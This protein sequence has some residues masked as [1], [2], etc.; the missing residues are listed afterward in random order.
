MGNVGDHKT[1]V[2]VKANSNSENQG[3]FNPLWSATIITLK[4][5]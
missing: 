2:G 3:N 1:T 4:Q 5:P